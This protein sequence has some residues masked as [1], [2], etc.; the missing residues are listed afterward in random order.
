ME[1]E[2]GGWVGGQH[3]TE[4]ATQIGGQLEGKRDTKDIDI[5]IEPKNS[6]SLRCLS[7]LFEE[8]QRKEGTL[9]GC[10]SHSL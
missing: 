5:K 1:E 9:E 3:K 7:P 6:Q 8:S 2:V 4:Q 10:K